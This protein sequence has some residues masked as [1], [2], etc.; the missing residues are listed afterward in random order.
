[1][2]GLGSQMRRAAVSVAAN[3]AEGYGR[4]NRGEYLHHLSIARGS[5]AELETL[6]MLG[7][8]VGHLTADALSQAAGLSDEVG[9][10]LLALTRRLEPTPDAR[11]TPSRREVGRRLHPTP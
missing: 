7:A 1:M 5:L 8:R 2:F 3:V 6:C 9:R 4:G 10:M 11:R